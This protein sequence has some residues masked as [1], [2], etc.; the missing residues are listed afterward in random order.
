MARTQYART[1]RD[2]GRCAG[3]DAQK[4]RR[5]FAYRGRGGVIAPVFAGLPLRNAHVQDP[6]CRQCTL[7]SKA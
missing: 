4:R 3:R 2:G 1:S 5:P 6:A 7:L